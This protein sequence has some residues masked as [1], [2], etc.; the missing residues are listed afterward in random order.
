MGQ[1]G[2]MD[3][4]H[5]S[6]SL[7]IFLMLAPSVPLSLLNHFNSLF[8]IVFESPLLNFSPWYILKLSPSFL[9]E[10]LSGVVYLLSPLPAFHSLLDL[11]PS[12]FSPR[13][14]WNLPPPGQQ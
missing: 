4:G 3:T 6:A 10:F 13:L 7:S 8:L 12:G 11:L 9:A 14:P 1:G 2:K 5:L